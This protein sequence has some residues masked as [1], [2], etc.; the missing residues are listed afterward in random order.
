[1]N[2]SSI[3]YVD[4]STEENIYWTSHVRIVLILSRTEFQ[5][6]SKGIGSICGKE[7][8]CSCMDWVQLFHPTNF[9]LKRTRVTAFIIDETMLQIGSDYAWFWVAIEPVH[10]Q[11]LGV[12][13]SRHR[14]MLVAES[15][16]RTLI[17][18]YGKHTVYSDG[19]SWYPEACSYLG[20]KHLLHTSFEKS[21]IERTIEYFKDRTE[22]FDDYYPCKN[23]I[24]YDLIHVHNWLGLF[25]F[26]HNADILDIK[27]MTLVRLMRGE[28]L[29]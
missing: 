7:K 27:F 28:S 25:V 8:S 13:V 17:K 23:T 1:V 11:V 15:F 26:M 3:V 9:Y 19:G 24:Q 6:Y 18:V 4:L 16:L 29:N 2:V 12:Y 10:K 22:H 20:L 14:N 21:I 5:K